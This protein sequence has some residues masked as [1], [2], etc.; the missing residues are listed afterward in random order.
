MTQLEFDMLMNAIRNEQD[1]FT[2][3]KRTELAEIEKRRALARQEF[4][5]MHAAYKCICKEIDQKQ[6]ELKS[7]KAQFY[8]R[9]KA[10]IQAFPKAYGVR[11]P[12]NEGMTKHT[13]FGIRAKMIEQLKKDYAD[14][15]HVDTERIDVHFNIEDSDVVFTTILPKKEISNG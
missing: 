10:L 4:D 13:L 9:K 12:H 8:E 14:S 2:A 7:A 5:A 3:Q 11:R 15:D 1:E 6:K